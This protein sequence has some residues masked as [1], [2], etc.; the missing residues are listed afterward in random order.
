MK[1]LQALSLALLLA[2]AVP[3]YSASD[4]AT[5]PAAAASVPHDCGKAVKPHDH[6][7]ERGTRAP[8]GKAAK[9]SMGCDSPT[10]AADS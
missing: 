6:G 1:Q 4:A 7:A 10:P 3:A 2:A 5:K 9:P 8:A